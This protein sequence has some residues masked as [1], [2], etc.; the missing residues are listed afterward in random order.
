[1]QSL[2]ILTYQTNPISSLIAINNSFTDH[3]IKITLINN[4]QQI[5][6]INQTLNPNLSFSTKLEQTKVYDLM[7]YRWDQRNEL[8]HLIKQFFHQPHYLICYSPKQSKSNQADF[9]QLM[10]SLKLLGYQSHI[11]Q[12]D[13]SNFGLAQ[14]MQ[15]SLI[16]S[17]LTTWKAKSGFEFTNFDPAND[18][19]VVPIQTILVADDHLNQWNQYSRYPCRLIKNKRI[20]KCLIYDQF[21]AARYSTIYDASGLAP[22]LKTNPL[23]KI[24]FSDANHNLICKVLNHQEISRC[25]GFSDHHYRTLMNHFDHKD[26]IKLIT[27]SVPVNI[28]EAVLKSLKF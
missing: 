15:I 7:I 19:Q 1:M 5:F 14:Q 10:Q 6:K 18:D 2:N 9:N 11:Y 26:V 8:Q 27:K 22:S 12:L 24:K 3:S 21:D 13:A 16:V 28:I 17:I 23:I 20:K 25:F 4:D